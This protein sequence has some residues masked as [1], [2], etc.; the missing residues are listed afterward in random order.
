[1]ADILLTILVPSI[2]TRTKRLGKLLRRLAAQAEDR[3]V[4]LLCWVDNMVRSIGR[5]RDD[6][7]QAAQGRFLAFVDD[8][9]NVPD[10]YVSVALEYIR[11]NPDA[12]VFAIQQECFW[13]GAGPYYVDF[14]IE[15][16]DEELNRTA[17][18][19]WTKRFIS[20][21]CIWRSSLAQQVNVPHKMYF[22]DVEWARDAAKLVQREI[23]IPRVMHIYKYDD[24]VSEGHDRNG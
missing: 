9:D 15:Y 22:E 18:G 6:L 24:L 7:I 17:P 12:D 8:D 3:P 2:T 23:R 4:E 20:H 16:T 5:K 10:C 21:S 14:S 11:A 19:A 13:N 1:M